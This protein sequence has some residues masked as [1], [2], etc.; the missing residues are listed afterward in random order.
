MVLLLLSVQVAIAGVALS[1]AVIVWRTTRR[2]DPDSSSSR[3]FSRVFVSVMGAVT[4][5]AVVQA[6]VSLSARSGASWASEWLSR[7]GVL[8]ASLATVVVL[9]A[10]RL[11]IARV[12]RD[13]VVA[14][15]AMGVVLGV[16][17]SKVGPMSEMGLTFREH[18][19]LAV[20]AA[21]LITDAELAEV[22][23]ISPATAATHVRNILRKTGLSDRRQLVVAGLID[24]DEAAVANGG[25]RS[26]T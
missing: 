6:L 20:T 11:T 23:F 1:L 17:H 15:R 18:E 2:L 7:W 4:L 22:L 24:G 14:D 8:S 19:V 10:A 21:G 9:A 25:G 16:V 5:L 26:V 13:L 3:R 12:L